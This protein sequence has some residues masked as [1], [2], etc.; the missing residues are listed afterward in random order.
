MKRDLLE[1]ENEELI[2]EYI[3]SGKIPL[4]EDPQVFEF[5]SVETFETLGMAWRSRI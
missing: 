1:W 2:K 5:D 4:D 3:K